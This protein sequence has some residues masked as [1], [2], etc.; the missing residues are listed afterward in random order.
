MP[1]KSMFKKRS[2]VKRKAKAKRKRRPRSDRTSLILRNLKGQCLPDKVFTTAKLVRNFVLVTGGLLPNGGAQ[3]TISANDVYSPIV[4]A[5]YSIN[6]AGFG[7][8]GS[9]ITQPMGLFNLLNANCYNK[10]RVH[11]CSC[12][13]S[14]QS[15]NIQDQLV[16]SI[17]PLAS[18]SLIPVA[19]GTYM[20]QARGSVTRFVNAYN[21]R[22]SSVYKRMKCHDIESVSKVQYDT[23]SQPPSG[24]VNTYGYEGLYNLS[25]PTKASYFITIMAADGL[26]NVG[27]LCLTM[28]INFSVELY[29]INDYAFTQQ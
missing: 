17:C 14:M 15:E 13:I 26:T 1:K 9:T 4:N 28:E 6:T 5:R 19:G 8:V 3:F 21:S 24:V 18:T 29:G 23:L 22:Q 11:A 7:N 10:F 25:P 2:P 20:E 12:K 16:L 27:D